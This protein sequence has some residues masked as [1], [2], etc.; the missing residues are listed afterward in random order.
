MS[1]LN[2]TDRLTR[3][4]E[5]ERELTKKTSAI[6]TCGK[7]VGSPDL[8]VLG[9]LRRTLAQARGFRDLIASKNFPCAAAILRLQIDTAMRVNALS[10][11]DNLDT[12][13]GK[14]LDGE[15]FKNLKSRHGDK[16]L[17]HYLRRKL[18]EENPWVDKVYEQTSDF[19]HLSG[20]HFQ[21]SI[22]HTDE[23]AGMA[24]FWISGVDP[25]R[26]DTEY[27]EVVDTF[28]KATKL[29]GILVLGFLMA[30]HQPEAV[31]MHN[32]N[33]AKRP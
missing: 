7:N 19:I 9:A 28:F 1:N 3:I 4:E 14:V 16:L 15:K 33:E 27:F 32:S 24:F 6:I 12:A 23:V 29:V 8:F 31:S 2:L 22:D 25:E 11:I 21:T 17:D 26:P 18:A 20:R 5:L 10:F 13:C 30:R